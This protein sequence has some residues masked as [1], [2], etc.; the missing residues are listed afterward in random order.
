MSTLELQKIRSGV[1]KICFTFQLF[2][3]MLF[4]Q[5][6]HVHVSNSMSPSNFIHFCLKESGDNNGILSFSFFRVLFL[7]SSSHILQNYIIHKLYFLKY[8][9][10]KE[11][12]AKNKDKFSGIHIF[13][14]IAGVTSEL[15]FIKLCTSID[16]TNR[17]LIINEI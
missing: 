12:T 1:D 14:K 17:I 3:C 5:P 16:K 10:Y 2:S 6:F 11:E 8:F 9:K 15:S 13:S 4:A 7:F